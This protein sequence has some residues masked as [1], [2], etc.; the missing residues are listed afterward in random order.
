MFK[1]NELKFIYCLFH[2]IILL[3]NK[4]LKMYFIYIFK[5]YMKNLSMFKIAFLIIDMQA[6]VAQLENSKYPKRN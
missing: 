4:I 3:Y 2:I 6:F 5:S 1:N